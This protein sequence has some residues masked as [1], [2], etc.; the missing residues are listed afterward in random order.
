MSDDMDRDD[1]LAWGDVPVDLVF[2]LLR[3][4][5]PLK[6][7]QSLEAGYVLELDRPLS[8]A[9]DI[10]VHGKRIGR[11]ELVVVQDRL[12]VRI[13]TLNG[14]AVDGSPD[15]DRESGLRS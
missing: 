1:D 13:V 15:D 5:M 3:L 4:R 6:Q 14:P 10:R 7:L 11:G 12:G 8:E 2:E 9:V